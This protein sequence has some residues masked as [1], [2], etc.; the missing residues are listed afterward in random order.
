MK[1]VSARTQTSFETLTQ[2]LVGWAREE[3]GVR[4]AFI[5]GSRARTDHPADE[6]SDLDIAILVV[7]PQRYLSDAEWVKQIGIPWLTFIESTGDGYFYERRVLFEGGYDV[8]FAFLPVEAMQ[9]VLTGPFAA[10][11]ANI[12]QRGVRLILDKDGLAAQII[13][14]APQTPL[15]VPPSQ[16]E[17]LNLVNDFWYHAVWTAK[18]MQRG[19]L[20]TA[21]SCCDSYM[22][23]RLLRIVEWHARLQHGQ[24]YDTWHSGRFLEEWADPRLVRGLRPAFSAYDEASLWRAL[25]ATMNLFHWLALE[26]AQRLGYPYPSSGEERATELVKKIKE[27]VRCKASS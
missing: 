22:K 18:K 20:W 24:D 7:D 12:F 25:F 5:L 19:E 21:K 9:G 4:S 6:S 23:W 2:K 8:D 14:A 26:T 17:F 10:D 13:A 27:S 3:A 15:P 16:E 1:K 11:L